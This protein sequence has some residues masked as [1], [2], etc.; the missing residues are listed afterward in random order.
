MSF[1]QS[2]QRRWLDL[3]VGLFLMSLL[4]FGSHFI[5]VMNNDARDIIFTNTLASRGQEVSKNEG[6]IACHTTDGSRGVGPSWQ[7]MWGR[8]E[9]LADGTQIVVGE[10]Y[11]IE[12]VRKPKAKQVANYPDVMQ[13]SFISDEDLQA[14]M[15]FVKTLSEQNVN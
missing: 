7:G 8:L 4:G 3:I 11:F 10:E 6:C 1:L 13:R 15:A 12:S 5:Y 9:S 2:P 14:I